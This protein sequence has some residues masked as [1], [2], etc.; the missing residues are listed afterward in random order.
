MKVHLLYIYILLNSFLKLSAALGINA[1]T[2]LYICPNAASN[3]NAVVSG[4]TPPFA[5]TWTPSNFCGTPN[6]ASTSTFASI[7]TNFTVTVTDSSGNTAQDVVAVFIDDIQYFGA[8]P[9]VGRC[10]LF[11]TPVSIGFTANYQGS[12]TYS[13]SPTTDLS[14]SA[15][16]QTLA[17]PT[18]TTTYTLTIN[19]I[20]CG[21][22]IDS[23][24]VN[25]YEVIADA[26]PNIT[27]DEGQVATL[28]GTGGYKYFWSPNIN[29]KY[30][31]TANPDVFP[32]VTQVYLMQAM[33]QHGC[34]AYDYDT[35]FVRPSSALIFYNT[36]SPNG[37]DNNDFWV[38][39]NLNKYPSNR[40][41]IYNRY[42][43]LIFKKTNYQND[44]NGTYFGEELPSGTYYYILDTNSE[45]G[46]FKG[47]VS[48]I[49]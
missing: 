22:I 4:G 34:S 36:F 32:V 8:G 40:L 49:R 42:G 18:V 29:I 11:G 41:E 43:Q 6:L 24:I 15:S 47:S 44:W 1:G 26:G 37:D 19:S 10:L 14:N 30:S 16:P 7:S 45:A 25:V 38:I 9:D 2:D 35:V 17:T 13:W 48:I 3:L 20:F 31:N 27:I 5:Y 33:D 21:S 28:H 39:S 46:K 23:V 12:Y